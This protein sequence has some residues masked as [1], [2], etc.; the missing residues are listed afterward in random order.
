MAVVEEEHILGVGR[1]LR[2]AADL[3][4]N[5]L[6]VAGGRVDEINVITLVAPHTRDAE[7]NGVAAPREGD[8]SV[9]RDT[10]L[11]ANGR[12][13]HHSLSRWGLEIRVVQREA[14]VLFARVIAIGYKGRLCTSA[15][16]SELLIGAQPRKE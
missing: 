4:A 7:Q 1:K 13:A 14:R 8:A 11:F 16:E 6:P 12:R 9:V 5:D 10:E 15:V 3:L 2:A